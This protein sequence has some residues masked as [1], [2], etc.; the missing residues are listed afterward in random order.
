M[1][2]FIVLWP[3]LLTTKL[4]SVIRLNLGHSNK[5]TNILLRD[6]GM[7][8]PILRPMDYTIKY[9]IHL[10]LMYR[11]NNKKNAI[12]SKTV[13]ILRI[14]DCVGLPNQNL[15]LHARVD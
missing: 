15:F 4:R 11:K 6:I 14:L 8:E 10:H 9:G 3:Y 13:C 12:S 7:G 2:V 1:A 5:H